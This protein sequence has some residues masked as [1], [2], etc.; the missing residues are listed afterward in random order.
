M[1]VQHYYSKHWNLIIGEVFQ[2]VHAT[3][4]V[5]VNILVGRKLVRSLDSC[6]V[7]INF[8]QIRAN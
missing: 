8:L 4:V 6:P 5:R 2:V 3:R 7:D 1:T